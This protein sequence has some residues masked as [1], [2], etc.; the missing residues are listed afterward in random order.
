MSSTPD[1]WVD[2]KKGYLA[3]WSQAQLWALWYVDKQRGLGLTNDDLR[4][5]VKKVGGGA[6]SD[7]IVSRYCKIFEEDKDWHPGK[8]QEGSKRPGPKIQFT[9][10]K[11][12]CVAKA[13]TVRL[14]TPRSLD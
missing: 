5:A 9:P 13:A 1:W 8:K 6:P 10:Q 4:K 12:L 2:G 14:A 3:P 7:S 11:K